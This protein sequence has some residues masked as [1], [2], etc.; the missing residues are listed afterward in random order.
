MKLRNLMVILGVISLL[1][2][3]MAVTACAP[4]P[5][6]Y[7]GPTS[8]TVSSGGIIVSQQSLGLWI[9]GTGK[10]TGTPDVVVLT[11]GVQSQ[12]KTVAQAQR[13]AVDAMNGIMQ[14]L[15]GAGVADKD[16]Q[17]TQ[18]NISQQTRW[19]EKQNTSVVIGYQVSNIVTVKIRDMGKAGTIIDKAAEAGG[20]LIRVNGI[21]FMVDDPTPLLKVARE[22]AIQNAIDKAKQMSQSSGASLGK[23]IY[24][25]ESTPY[26]PVVQNSYMKLSDASG[27]APAP[28]AI[29][30]GEL[31]FQSNV[32]LV[33][34]IN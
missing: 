7:Q 17:T 2:A 29:S 3:V 24:I 6:V 1:T 21:S 10:A 15:K 22:K 4:S 18:F 32:Q 33:Y 14:V 27:M 9:N 26:I 13:A 8:S 25:S 12:D 20:D 11:L 30:A 34:Q 28:T 16:I 23:L 31:E 5:V 19:D